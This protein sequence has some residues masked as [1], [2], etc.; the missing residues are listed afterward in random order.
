M[1]TN[2]HYQLGVSL[3]GLLFWAVLLGFAALVGMKLF[4]LYNEKMQVDKAMQN[5]A[6]SATSTTG[7]ADLV[8]N[9]LRQFE[10]A[11]VDR[12]DNADFFRLLQVGRAPNSTKRVMSLEYEIRGPFFGDLDVVLKYKRVEP[13]P[14]SDLQ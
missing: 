3:S 11:D 4:P 8:K 5:A 13:L 2:R 9:I 10:V 7:K 14:A 12:W 6:A 1:G